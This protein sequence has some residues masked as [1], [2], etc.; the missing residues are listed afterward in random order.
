[1]GTNFY[2][3][4]A[5]A[6]DDRDPDDLRVHIG[7]RSGA[8]FYCWD[9]DETL[10]MHGIAGV[11]TGKS[12]WFDACPS[13]GKR[14]DA[15]EPARV[16]ERPP[17]GVAKCCSFTWAASPRRV[18]RLC[19]AHPDRLLVVDE[20]GVELTGRQFL[21]MLELTCPIEIHDSIGTRFS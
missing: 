12:A 20:S 19:A 16:N 21:H 8:G 6:D 4:D 14:K 1:M 11:H 17:T 10:H 13:C 9:C 3:R 18:R 5:L 2:W 7:K 15:P